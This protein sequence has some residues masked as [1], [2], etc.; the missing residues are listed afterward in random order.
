[1]IGLTTI[2]A[3]MSV[4]YGLGFSFYVAGLRHVPASY[5]GAFLPLIPVFGVAAG[6]LF[7]ERLE[8]RQ[9]LGALVIVAATVAIAARHHAE[10]QRL[11]IELD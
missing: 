3:S 6:Y 7:G 4:Y 9:W 2:T 11:P 8:P 5:A 1:L 10:A